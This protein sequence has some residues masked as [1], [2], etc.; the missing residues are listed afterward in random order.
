MTGSEPEMQPM[1]LNIEHLPASHR[2]QAI[3][4]GRAC[5]IDYHLSNGV[6]TI[7]H[8][9]VPPALE[10]RGIAGQ[11]TRAVLDHVR[12]HGLKVEPACSYARAYID[13]HPEDRDLL[14]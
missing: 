13:R 4:D 12:A 3:V 7:L 1:D 5:V 11:L 2:F 8:T 14:A 10:G 6:L 9:G